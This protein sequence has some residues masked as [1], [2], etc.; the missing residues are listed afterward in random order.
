MSLRYT[1]PIA[2]L[3]AM[4]LISAAAT[5]QTN[6]TKVGVVRIDRVFTQMQ[7]TQDLNAKRNA[8]SKRLQ[9]EF[10]I[11]KDRVQSLKEAR[12][13]LKPESPQYLERNKEYMDEAVKLDAW[14]RIQEVELGRATKTQTRTLYQKIV[15]A[16][17]EVAQQQGLDLVLNDHRVDMPT[18]QQFE[19]MRPE[20]FQQFRE[21]LSAQNVV[22]AGP[23]TDIT[24]DVL[25]LL[26]SRYTAQGKPGT[27]PTK[28]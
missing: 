27:A 9:A 21:A 4:C 19:Q 16:V 1:A 25:A 13:Q 22:Y 7:E 11:Q 8:D 20:Q 14:M 17:A 15:S 23:K 5:A 24:A 2:L 28:P 3:A 6:P 26:N 18:D 10:A 12:D